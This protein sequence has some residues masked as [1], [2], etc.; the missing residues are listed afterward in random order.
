MF[1]LFKR[2]KEI[3]EIK[4]EVR[5]SF[6]KVK[7]D[8]NKIGEWVNHLNNQDNSLK[9]HLNNLNDELSTLKDE[10]EQLKEVISLFGD[11]ISKQ[12]FKTNRKLINKQTSVQDNQTA[13]QTAV[14]TSEFNGISN[15]SVTERA[16]L[17]V[18]INNDLKLSYEDIAAILGKTT[19]TI[20]GQI[21]S[22]KQKSEGIIEEYVESNG[23]KRIYLPEEIKEKLL[24]NRKV[25]VKV[26]TKPKK[27]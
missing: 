20:R 9:S 2:K 15:L 23:K 21:N 7:D 26:D 14:Q 11:G 13:V 3:E 4:K 16:I 19:S 27:N 25:R 6:E 8:I 12:L 22:I 17:W 18:L 5:G 1:E 10:V 24:K